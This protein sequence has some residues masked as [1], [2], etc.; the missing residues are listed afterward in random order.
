MSAPKK[1]ESKK[2]LHDDDDDDQKKIK[3]K[4]WDDTES[5]KLEQEI[6]KELI[7]KKRKKNRLA[8]KR[9][10]S[11]K[12]ADELEEF[13]ESAQV[14]IA[15]D[16]SSNSPGLVIVDRSDLIKT[17]PKYELFGF[18]QTDKQQTMFDR[19]ADQKT[20]TIVSNVGKGGGGGTVAI[21]SVERAP[22]D[23]TFQ[24]N[25]EYYEIITSKLMN[26]IQKY[27]N[28]KCMAVIE[29]YAFSMKQ[30][31]S[32]TSLAELGGVMRNKLFKSGIRIFEVPP[33]S[34]KKW[35][36]GNGSADKVQMWKQFQKISP[37]IK[38][39]E[40]LPSSCAE[41]KIPSPHQDIVDAFASAHSLHERSFETF[42]EL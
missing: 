14:I 13:C 40:W 11:Q 19:L 2:R 32:Q 12:S 42:R 17:G 6:D 37:D 39:L 21:L 20:R 35:F 3:P 30:S 25:T 38:L 1:N 16:M 23:G 34:I 9:I 29:L 33:T 7:R 36:T 4:L 8:N 18:S 24:H 27:A 15:L 26:I 10:K 31:S 28:K 5:K 22:K 41:N